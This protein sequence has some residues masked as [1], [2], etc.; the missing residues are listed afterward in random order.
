M[1][2]LINSGKR[3]TSL[4]KGT[5]VLHRYGHFRIY[6]CTNRYLCKY[7]S[8]EGGIKSETDKSERIQFPKNTKGAKDIITRIKASTEM[9]T[10]PKSLFKICVLSGFVLLC[11]SRIPV[12]KVLS[13]Y[14]LSLAG[15]VLQCTYFSPQMGVH[16]SL[17]LAYFIDPQLRQ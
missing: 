2:E 12:N 14:C 11:S 9:N 8:V 6:I 13:V 7:I 5:V 17:W 4:F 15:F 16:I 10:T 3:E 1:A